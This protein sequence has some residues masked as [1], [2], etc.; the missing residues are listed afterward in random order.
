MSHHP[1]VTSEPALPLPGFT[2]AYRPWGAVGPVQPQQRG[3][4][5]AKQ[6]RGSPLTLASRTQGF[7][8]P[9]EAAA[10][11]RCCSHSLEVQEHP[12]SRSGAY[13]LIHVIKRVHPQSGSVEGVPQPAGIP[14]R[15][16]A[17]A[18]APLAPWHHQLRSSPLCCTAQAPHKEPT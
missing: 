9:S 13:S 15:S 14:A 5:C 1:S 16:G 18:R 10:L 12:Q 7:I 6:G 2:Q 11:Q 17:V 3:S 4:T 8:S